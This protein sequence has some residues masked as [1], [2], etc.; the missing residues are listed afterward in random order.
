VLGVDEGGWAP[1]PQ[2]WGKPLRRVVYCRAAPLGS[3][4][5]APRTW[6]WTNSQ[7]VWESSPSVF[8][9]HV[10]IPISGCER[11]GAHVSDGKGSAVAAAPPFFLWCCAVFCGVAPAWV[12]VG[13][14]NPR[15]PPQPRYRIR[16]AGAWLCG[17]LVVMGNPWWMARSAHVRCSGAPSWGSRRIDGPPQRM[18]GAG[19]RTAAALQSNRRRRPL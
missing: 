3:C 17:V 1:Y 10:G 19:P 13:S 8:P 4:A 11:P 18:Q 6:G 16:P 12:A 7:H 2:S 5:S 15:C 14:P 9:P